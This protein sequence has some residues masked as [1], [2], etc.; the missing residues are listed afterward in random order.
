MTFRPRYGV[1][2]ENCS[3]DR[4]GLARSRRDRPGQADP[5][6][7]RRWCH[8]GPRKTA[9]STSDSRTRRRPAR[10][11]AELSASS[12]V[13]DQEK[14][15]LQL[16]RAT[17]RSGRTVSGAAEDRAA[18]F[19]SG[20]GSHHAF[21]LEA[22]LHRFRMSTDDRLVK[23]R[24]GVLPL[25]VVIDPTLRAELSVDVRSVSGVGG[26]GEALN[27][28]VR[29]RSPSDRSCR[30]A[31]V[32]DVSSRRRDGPA[33]GFGAGTGAQQS[34]GFAAARAGAPQYLGSSKVVR[35]SGPPTARVVW[36]SCSLGPE[37]FCIPSET[38][39]RPRET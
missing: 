12:A 31:S 33:G 5:A 20:A 28:A 4:R 19:V 36:G 9:T 27:C 8:H 37:T 18:L 29:A 23:V 21:A 7:P 35:T 6:G 10:R 11:L 16:A 15:E 14:A 24:V 22:G 25:D 30:G 34:Q 3:P 32:A 1:G 39:S 2:R 13:L 17:R 26:L 38:R